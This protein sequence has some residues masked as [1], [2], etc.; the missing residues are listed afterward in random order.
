MV[1]AEGQADE[2]EEITPLDPDLLRTPSPAD[3]QMD[4][5]QDAEDEE[6]T[7]LDPD[8]LRTPSPVDSNMHEDEDTDEDYMEDADVGTTPPPAETEGVATVNDHATSS[9]PLTESPIGTEEEEE[10]P[11]ARARPRRQV[12]A[13]GRLH[14]RAF[15][16]LDPFGLTEYADRVVEAFQAAQV[17]VN[18]FPFCRRDWSAQHTSPRTRLGPQPEGLNMSPLQ[19]PYPDTQIGSM[20]C[21]AWWARVHDSLEYR[22]LVFDPNRPFG[23]EEHI[24][25]AILT[26]PQTAVQRVYEAHHG[27]ILEQGEGIMVASRGI[28]ASALNYF[29]AIV[30]GRVVLGASQPDAPLSDEEWYEWVDGHPGRADEDL[31]RYMNIFYHALYDYFL[32]TEGRNPRFHW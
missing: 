19:L 16:G 32:Y 9:S 28:A 2:D 30:A 12:A 18:E 21:A 25:A 22:R 3:R 31:F 5:E 10:L 4:E 14:L 7:P 20:D 26:I 27:Y 6:I 8:L 13:R 24:K 17:L 23:T 1:E 11:K 29:H 15:L